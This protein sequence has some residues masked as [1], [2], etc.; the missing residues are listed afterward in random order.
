MYAR[1]TRRSSVLFPVELRRSSVVARFNRQQH[2]PA[3]RTDKEKI[4]WI[5]QDLQHAR[6]GY[7]SVQEDLRVLRDRVQGETLMAQKR[8]SEMLKLRQSI[9][10]VNLQ[11]EQAAL[12]RIA[13]FREGSRFVRY[14]TCPKP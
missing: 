12:L 5:E 10:D 8:N 14:A 6:N 4:E 9:G 7:Y 2:A 3:A 1:P 13:Y 11:L